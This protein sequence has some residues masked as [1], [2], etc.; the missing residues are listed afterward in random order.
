MAGGRGPIFFERNLDMQWKNRRS[1]ILKPGFSTPLDAPM[2]PG[3]PFT[4]HSCN[5]L[6][7]VYRTDPQA[8]SAL[9]PEPLIATGDAVM[10]HLY[11][12]NDTE[13]LGPYAEANVMVGA[14]LPGKAVGSYSPYLFLSS[15]IGVAHGREIHGQ[16]K[17]LAQPKVEFRGDLIV[18]T[19]ERNGIEIITGTMPYKQQRADISELADIFPFAT[20]INLKAVDH[21]DGRPA[22]R[23]LTSRSLADVTVSE[24]WRGPSTVELRP[25]AQ[26]PVHRLPVRE[27]L[28]SYYWSA[29]FTLVPGVILLDYLEEENT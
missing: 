3:F 27:M 25:N 4:F 23:Q 7:L 28:E 12:M 17:K 8:I 21:I 2:I 20:N 11:Q 29:S 18:G 9:L 16:P 22:I 26:A 5:I 13:W 10:I 14:E 19:V 6:T 1:D 24:C 15:D